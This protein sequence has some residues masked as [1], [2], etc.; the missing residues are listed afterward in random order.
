[1][2]IPISKPINRTLNPLE[3]TTKTSTKNPKPK[4]ISF[5]NFCFAKSHLNQPLNLENPKNISPKTSKHYSISPSS[6]SICQQ[7]FR[8][9]AKLCSFTEFSTFEGNIRVLIQEV[10][11][12][13]IFYNFQYISILLI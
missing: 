9:R 11:Y 3:I 8:F 6:Q 7:K 4:T 12:S 10:Q 5:P 13:H 1:M 2:P